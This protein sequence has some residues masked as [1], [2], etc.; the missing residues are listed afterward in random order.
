MA[1]TTHRVAAQ[2][3]YRLRDGVL[4]GLAGERQIHSLTCRPGG[5]VT[6]IAP[7]R[8]G[9]TEPTRHPVFGLIA[10][11]CPSDPSNGQQKGV[12]NPTRPG[13]TSS[14][15]LRPGGTNSPTLRPGVLAVATIG[16]GGVNAW[17]QRPGGANA[18]DQRPGGVNAWDQRPG[19]TGAARGFVLGKSPLGG[20]SLIVING[21][22]EL[23]EA[24]ALSGGGSFD[25]VA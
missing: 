9:I 8:Y 10:F 21:F 24:L 3:T 11:A 23:M 16:L 7:G 20:N 6:R 14:P 18:W 22:E 19:G 25:V 5:P 4:L 2:L 15:T 1:E 13:G 17:D 12:E